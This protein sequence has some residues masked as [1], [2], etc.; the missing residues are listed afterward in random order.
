MKRG[1]RKRRLTGEYSQ[2]DRGKEW[3][4][5]RKEM[6][7]KVRKWEDGRKEERMIQKRGYE[8]NMEKKNRKRRKRDG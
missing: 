3:E 4:N 2:E 8:R 7:I 6:S 5:R 1:K